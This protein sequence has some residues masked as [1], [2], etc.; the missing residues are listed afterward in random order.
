[1]QQQELLPFEFQGSIL[2]VERDEDGEPVFH[3]GDLCAM[4]GYANPRDAVAQH[5]EPCDVVKRDVTY[6]DATGKQRKT[7][8]EN[9]VREPGLWCLIL[10]SHA[11]NAL[12]IRRWVTAEVLPAIRKTGGYRVKDSA[13]RPKTP[14]IAQQLAA[15]PLRLRLLNELERERNPEKREAIHQQLAHASGLL[16]L[17]TPDKDKIGFDHVPEPVPSIVQEFWEVYDFLG[18]SAKLNHAINAQFIAINLT[19]FQRVAAAAKVKIPPLSDLRRAL[20]DSLD[21]R[22]VGNKPV[23]SRLHRD[24]NRT[25]QAGQCLPESIRCWLFEPVQPPPPS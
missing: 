1:M 10:G 11:A 25:A 19:H 8:L 24:H 16:G 9:W 21:P 12:P 2:R 23:Q 5:V 17:P 4:L 6:P 20:V 7:Q 13:A 14:S 3:A 15:H 18:G 22:Y